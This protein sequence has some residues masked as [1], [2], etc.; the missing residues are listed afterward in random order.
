MEDI[1]TRNHTHYER[2]NRRTV[3][4]NMSSSAKLLE[5]SFDIK[6]LFYLKKVSIPK[7][8]ENT[9]GENL[10]RLLSFINPL[11]D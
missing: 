4:R 10:E 1:R 9:L 3:V 7:H 2:K 6:T 8:T 11:T 5:D